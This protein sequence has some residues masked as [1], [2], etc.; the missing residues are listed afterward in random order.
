MLITGAGRGFCAGQDLERPAGQARRED[1]ARRDAWRQYY[2][3]LIRKLR[4]L[5]FPVVAA[6]NG[7]AAGAGANIALACD[8]V[9]AARSATFL[10]AFAKHR[11]RAGFRRHL[12]SAAAR[13]RRARARAGAARRAADGGEGREW[14]LIWKCVDDGVLMRRGRTSCAHVS[15]PRRP[16]A[17]A[18]QARARR[19]RDQRS[20]AQLDLERDLQREAGSTPDY[21][22]GVGPSWKSARRISPAAKALD[23]GRRERIARACA[24]AMWAEDSREPGARH[25]ADLGRA[26]PRGPRHD[27]DRDE[28]STATTSCHGGYIFTLADSAF[29]FACNTYNQRAV[30]Q[31]C[32][33]TFVNRRAAR[34]PADRPRRRASSAPAAPASTTSR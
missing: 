23:H 33:I 4:N 11:P 31:H 5:P 19:R 20:L 21:A 18:D 13:R 15:P 29:A 17:F 14:G 25:A 6:V 9:I 32:A 7:V 26:G 10:Q 12:V 30:A 22:E 1:R 3:P 8:I 2:N 34:R 16:S 27:G 28:W 24:D